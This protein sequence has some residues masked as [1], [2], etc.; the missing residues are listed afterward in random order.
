MKGMIGAGSESYNQ[1]FDVVDLTPMDVEE[2]VID[3]S[4]LL[5]G[6]SQDVIVH[7]PEI[8]CPLNET[9]RCQFLASKGK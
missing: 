4:G 2:F 6:A 8:K 9:A 5:P 3:L 7:V 1:M